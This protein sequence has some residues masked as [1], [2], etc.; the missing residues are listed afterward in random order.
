MVLPI[1]PAQKVEFFTSG[2]ALAG[3]S[4]FQLVP[5][6]NNG[7]STDLAVVCHAG[8]GQVQIAAFVTNVGDPGLTQISPGTWYFNVYRYVSAAVGNPQLI[9]N[10]YVRNLNGT[11]TLLF[12]VG[13]GPIRDIS[14][15]YQ[16]ITYTTTTATTINNTDR[17]VVRVFASASSIVNSVVHFVFDGSVYTSY[18]LAPIPIIVVASNGLTGLIGPTGPQGAQGPPG[19]QG[20]QGSPGV[21]GSTGTAGVTG[22]TGPRGATGSQGATGPQGA[23][24]SQGPQGSPGV[25]GSTGPQGAQG[26]QGSPGVTGVTGPTGPVGAQGIQ[27]SPGVT[28]ATGPTGPQ[29]SQGIQGSPGVTGATGPTGPQGS[30]GVQGSPGVTGATGP[31]GPA[32]SQGS[33][34]SPGVTGVTGA[35][36][37]NAY[38]TNYG[39]TQPAVGAAIPV[40][41]P[42]G[43]W[44]Q[45][46]QYVFIP[47]GGYYTIASGSVPTFSLQNLGYSGINIPVGSTVAT[48]FISPGGIAGVTGVTGPQGATGPGAATIA[49]GE[50]YN[51]TGFNQLGSA[52]V[53]IFES[54]GISANT[55]LSGATG[56][57]AV[58][59]T[60][61]YLITY[62][63]SLSN[64]T[65]ST[66]A[67]TIQLY[68]NGTVVSQGS[69]RDPGAD[70]D[71]AGSA[72]LTLNS[73]DYLQLFFNPN[74]GITSDNIAMRFGDFC[75]SAIG[76]VQGSTGT[77]GPTGPQ[78]SPGVTGPTGPQGSQG[79]Q[80]VT[81]ATG[82]T[83]P[84]G[85]QGSPGVTGVTGVPGINAYST[86]NGFTQPAVG[87]SI[88]VQAPS[89][90]WMQVGQYVFI[91]SGGYYTVASGSA[92]TFS[93][94]NLGYSGVNIPVGSSVAAGF[95][96]PGG[97]AGV[98]GVTGPT[99]PQGATGPT[100]PQ[101]ATG[102]TGAPGI[103][104]YSTTAGFTQPAV[105][106]TVAIQVPSGYW[107]Q[108][109]QYVFIPSGGY[110]TVASGSAPTFS[111]QNLGYSGIN[112]PVGSAVSAAFVS[113]GGVAGATGPAGSGGSSSNTPQLVSTNYNIQS[114][115]NVLFVTSVAGVVVLTLPS[116]PSLGEMHIIKDSK[117][118]ARTNNISIAG[119][120]NTVET[121][122]GSTGAGVTLTS[123][124]DAITLGWGSGIWNI[125]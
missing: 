114:T 1:V 37:I 113:P 36:G 6:A 96:S 33:Q 100:G 72:V 111:I 34:G 45:P 91:P 47:S 116:A 92:P 115:D 78:G 76:G 117:G 84:Q 56:S 10:V 2:I 83:G 120:G 112:I 102:V 22:A 52:Q 19:P 57:I 109:G 18:V 99:G 61:Q 90:Y 62:S 51:P 24:G 87:T 95:V 65:S 11:E 94:K 107:M 104:A 14:V 80:G 98:T 106:T 124:F 17:L 125:L 67:N 79:I 93:L 68:K 77:T 46:G 69:S 25:T 43:Y 64:S 39:F 101:G 97:I 105:G 9:F 12:S 50:L 88:L 32:G 70:A 5:T 29:G 7:L 118:T 89:G 66:A 53:I 8:T 31:T 40:Q 38:S 85:A 121:W 41:I 49:Y 13:S 3:G 42:S 21:T 4:H 16:S 48:G 103:N 71:L 35:A 122:A 110:Y 63:V 75:V 28:G 82:P 59:V 119:N 27:G 23:T 54:A 30:Q 123:N 15:A 26:P 60:G 73:G 44:L 108:V 20:P 74:D 81:G 86:T 55:T 58:N